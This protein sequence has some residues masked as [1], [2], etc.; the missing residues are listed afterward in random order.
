MNPFSSLALPGR[1][2]LLV[3][4]FA[5]AESSSS[6]AE[7]EKRKGR[8]NVLM[9]AIDDLN[10]WAV[11]LSQ[12]AAAKTPHIDQLANRGVLFTNAHCAAPACN[13][14]RAAVM[15]GVR[16]STSGV[17]YNWQDWR[18]CTNLRGVSTLPHCF[19][20]HGYK[21]LGCGKLYHAANLSQWGLAGYLDAS[22]WDEYF[23]SK[24][25]QLADEVTPK[26]N[27]INGSNQ[28]YHGRFDWA[29][30]D[31]VD[32]QMGD[33]KVVAWA[34]R[35]LSRRHDKPLFLAVGIYRP[36]IPW[37]TPQKWFDQYP[38]ESITLPKIEASDLD[39]IPEAGQAMAR[40]PWQKWIVDNGKWR[41][42]VQGYLASVSFADAMVGR[43][44]HAL[45]SG[46]H[47][48]NTVIVLWSDHGYHLGHKEHWEKFALWEQTTH[49][50]LIV[51]DPAS[52]GGGRRCQRPTSLLDVYPTLVDLCGLNTPEHLEGQSLVPFL[53]NPNAPSSRAVV[54]TQGRG[55]H[56][57]R[58]QNWR[59]IRYADGS[60]ELYDH[61]RDPHEFDNLA[62]APE[63][64]SVIRKLTAHLPGTDSELNPATRS[65]QGK[66]S[67]PKEND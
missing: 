64:H 3:S 20:D 63:H 45:D 2:L 43:L 46:P 24:T 41:E 54:T 60:Q 32:S 59:Y 35:Q 7:E 38:V 11:G 37:H 33:G 1:L 42:A 44:L 4:L 26:G 27:A 55:N 14:S 48:G 29:P 19:R 8:P 9:I 21:V 18:E 10:D 36:H 66:E 65:Q 40:R 34:E 47:A 15:T 28:F 53:N 50:P 25:R 13:P 12:Y 61:R 31:I 5:L 22:P 52:T 23:P 57:V 30:L 49:V 39:D 17:Y 58:S 6:C 16:P 62:D 67:P 56:A 51:A